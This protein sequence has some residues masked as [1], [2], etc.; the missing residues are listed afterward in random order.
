MRALGLS[1]SAVINNRVLQLSKIPNRRTDR[2]NKE[3]YFNT[4]VIADRFAFFAAH[5]T[6]YD[7]K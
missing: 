7:M 4:A 5:I 1:K 6:Y 2:Y 3:V